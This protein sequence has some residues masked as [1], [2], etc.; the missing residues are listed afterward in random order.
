MQ[1]PLPDDVMKIV[2][3]GAEKEDKAAAFARSQN[4]A[5]KIIARAHRTEE[6][7][8]FR[9]A[10]VNA[11]VQ[12]EFEASI[13]ITR[14]VLQGLNR[15]TNEVKRALEGIRIRRYDIFQPNINEMDAAI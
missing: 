12:P 6:I 3:R 9:E 14:L 2:M 4:A 1:Q 7:P 15:P 13:E 8:V 11:V 5:L 10:G